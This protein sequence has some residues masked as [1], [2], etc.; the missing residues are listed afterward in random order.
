MRDESGNGKKE[1]E[2]KTYKQKKQRH[3]EMS[4]RG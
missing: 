3:W 2:M 1:K 4:K